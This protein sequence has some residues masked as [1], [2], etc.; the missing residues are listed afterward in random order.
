MVQRKSV[1]V[2]GAGVSGLAAA[3][4]FKDKGHDVTILD[5]ASDIGGVW[6]LSRSYPDVQTQS[7]KDLY[8]YTS[9]PM[10]KDYPEWP[11]GPQVHA[12]LV[13]YARENGLIG[14]IRFQTTVTAMT[15]RDGAAGWRLELGRADGGSE[16]VDYDFVAVCIGHFNE[17]NM[18]TF[19]GQPEF[20]AGGGQVMHSSQYNDASLAKG[21]DVVVL[22]F[23][24]SATD[25]AVNALKSGAKSVTIVYRENV[26]RVPYFIGG[27]INFKKILYIRA[28][29]NMFPSWD[30]RLSNRVKHAIAKPFIWANWRALESLLAIQLK[31]KKTGLRPKTPIETGINCS[32]PIVTPGL[33]DMIA[34]GR[35]RAIQGTFES[36]ASGTIKLTGGETLTADLAILAVGWKIGVPFLSTEYQQKLIDPDGQFR[37]FR[38]I[39]NPDI[40]DMGFVGFNSSF[41][42]VLTAEMAANWLVRY[43]DG[44]LAKQPTPAEMRIDIDKM[45]HWKRHI[46]PAAG[47]YGGLCVAPWHFRHFDELLD[48][49]GAKTKRSNPLA[50]NLAPPNA[51]LYARYLASTPA[52]M[53]E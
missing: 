11:K 38:V 37:L 26:W 17:R 22:G 24:K 2:I 8:R 51:D 33:Y 10:P 1:C 43:A 49:M 29:E 46:R 36:Y 31:F 4:A 9:K 18:L 5:K 7:P 20:E 23:S 41:C 3:K 47:V 44:R 14:L 50:D 21:K 12:Y 19:P 13:D 30:R 35:I 16:T 25:I 40:P 52:Y 48:D 45:L 53:A 27:L 39:A 34:D 32:V 15:K 28:Q 6:V 42:S